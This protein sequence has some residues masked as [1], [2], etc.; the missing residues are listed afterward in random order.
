MTRAVVQG[1]IIAS[2]VVTQPVEVSERAMEQKDERPGS[3]QTVQSAMAISGS[4]SAL[5]RT[6]KATA[7]KGP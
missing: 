6:P 4:G 7:K 1:C 5:L 2:F 3:I